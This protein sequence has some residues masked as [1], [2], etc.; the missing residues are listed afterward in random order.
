MGKDSNLIQLFFFLT[1]TDIENDIYLITR[2]S[3]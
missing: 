3:S 2:R 1:T